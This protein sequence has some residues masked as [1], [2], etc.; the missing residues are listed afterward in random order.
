[1]KKIL[2]PTDFSENAFSASVYAAEMA[3]RFQYSIHFLH[4]YTAN[5]SGFDEEDVLLEDQDS[6][7]LKADLTIK[8][9]MER[10]QE[11]YPSLLL[12]YHNDRGLLQEVLPREANREGYACI[13]MGTT[14][15]SANKNIFW[16]SNTAFIV[17]KSPIPV[18][19]IPNIQACPRSIRKAG[20]LTNFKQEELTTLQEFTH[21]FKQDI[22]IALIHVYKETE[23]QASIRNRLDSWSFNVAEFCAVKQMSQLIASTRK[24]DSELDQIPEVIENLIDHDDVDMILVSRTRRSFFSRLFTPS[25]SKAMTLRLQKPAF[26]GKT[27]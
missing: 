26:F 23:Q 6:S 14:G 24:D 2:V 13:V 12:S 25:V 9:W 18:I 3:M 20:L 17:A 11:R 16:G 7:L 1:M 8:D 19:V 4:C 10:I 5:S 15:A 27:I 21:I 22:D